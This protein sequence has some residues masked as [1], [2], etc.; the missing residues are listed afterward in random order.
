MKVRCG[1]I[2]VEGIRGRIVRN[3]QYNEN[4]LSLH[5]WCWVDTPRAKG[6]DGFHEALK[7]SIAETG[8]RNPV[9]VYALPE[10]DFIAFGTS[11]YH[12]V[13]ELGHEEIYALV[14][15]H[16]D[17]YPDLDE[18]TPENVAEFFK[19]PPQ[20]I[21]FTEDG[22][23]YHYGIERNRRNSYDPAGLAWIN[24][25]PLWLKQEFGWIAGHNASGQSGPLKTK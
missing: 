20:V 8:L 1:Y 9:I 4:H 6:K 13:R 16:A 18:V 14:N 7:A 11:R 5:G 23:D 22:A 3:D 17:R 19:D 12:A 25:D 10:G 2:P 15:D 21:E 24:G